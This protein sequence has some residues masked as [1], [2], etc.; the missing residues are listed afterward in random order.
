MFEDSTQGCWLDLLGESCARRR[1]SPLLALSRPVNPP[2]NIFTYLPSSSSFLPTLACLADSYISVLSVQIRRPRHI[3]HFLH[4]REPS[5][6]RCRRK[7]NSPGVSR[8]WILSCATFLSSH[9]QRAQHAPRE[10]L[11]HHNCCAT[12]VHEISVQDTYYLV[13]VLS[14]DK[15][16]LFLVVIDATFNM[17]LLALHH[18][19]AASRNTYLLFVLY[20]AQP[21]VENHIASLKM[22][23]T[24]KLPN[25]VKPPDIIK[26]YKMIIR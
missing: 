14:H 20:R 2:S 10:T 13:R 23:P 3:F 19:A 12:H 26:I 24:V 15:S 11:P 8:A 16:M 25:K 18:T 22:R 5:Q 6:A 17:D 9:P 4:A 1:R 21:P 7:G